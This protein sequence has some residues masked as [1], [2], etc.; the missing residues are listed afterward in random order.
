MYDI[1]TLG[2]ATVDVFVKTRKPQIVKH[3]QH[4]DVCY[5][6]GEK[7]L[8]DD[9]HVDTGG[10]GTNTA[11]AFSRL[12]LKTGWVGK[13][14]RDLNA[15]TV[16]DEMRRENV[17]VLVSR[18]DG[19]ADRGRRASADTVSRRMTGYS[20]ILTGLE[21][22]RTIL[23]YKGVNDQ[24]SANDVPW[25]KLNTKWLYLSAMLGKSFDS[26][27]KAAQFA[28]KNNIKYAFNASM[29]LAKQG[30]KALKP[31]IE[32]CDVLVLNREEAQALLG[33]QEK[34]RDMLPELQKY[35]KIT[36]ITDGPKPAHAYNG[37]DHYEITPP[38][39]KVVETTGAGDA[40]ASGFVA[41]LMVKKDIA[42]ALQ[43]AMAESCAVIQHIGAKQKLLKRKEIERA[44]PAKL[45]VTRL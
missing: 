6:I 5:A 15:K 40:F 11:V 16:L 42:A 32:G 25:K 26:L 37:I 13:L 44:K 21:H 7:V 20:V 23:A 19:S 39:I 18:G 3:Q 12:G 9:L 1:V 29:Y 14:G 2:S 8:V 36:V 43:W 10:G 4:E 31:I 41:G 35:A 30:V 28:K 33:T 45:T 17:D 27:V 24:L 22:D 34:C 38:D